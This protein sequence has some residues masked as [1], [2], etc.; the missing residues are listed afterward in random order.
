MAYS[1]VHVT[2][3]FFVRRDTLHSIVN[4]SNPVARLT[5]DSR[6][7]RIQQSWIA[8]RCSSTGRMGVFRSNKTSVRKRCNMHTNR[9]L[10]WQRSRWLDSGPRGGRRSALTGIT[11]RM[12]PSTT[13]CTGMLEFVIN[14]S[15]RVRWRRCSTFSLPLALQLGWR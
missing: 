14:V 6:R 2:Y 4:V 7:H 13:C 8:V 1:L 12:G 10:L 3:M 11:G 9:P 5:T 15:H